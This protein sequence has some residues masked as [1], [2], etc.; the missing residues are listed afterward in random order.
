MSVGGRWLLDVVCWN[1]CML[2]YLLVCLLISP[3]VMFSCGWCSFV[4][5]MC[6]LIFPHWY[7][8]ETQKLFKGPQYFSSR[9]WTHR[10]LIQLSSQ[11][12]LD[13][14]NI[15]FLVSPGARFWT[16]LTS[17]IRS[18]IVVKFHPKID[19]E[20][21]K[22]GY[23]LVWALSVLLSTLFISPCRQFEVGDVKFDEAL[24]ATQFEDI[25]SQSHIRESGKTSLELFF[26]GR[27]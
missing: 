22:A 6:S 14:I 17:S 20:T 24:G 25:E 5:L 10:V 15:N 27:C 23:R 12:F 3:D 1:G 11:T 9:F 13:E 8:R 26:C 21:K 18:F 4:A 19:D 16:P 2:L 7:P